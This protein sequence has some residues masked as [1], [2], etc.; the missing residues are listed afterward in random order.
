VAKTMDSNLKYGAV[1]AFSVEKVSA[2]FSLQT[3]LSSYSLE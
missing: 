2:D 1:G 3:I